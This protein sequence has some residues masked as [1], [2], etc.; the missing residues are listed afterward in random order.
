MSLDEHAAE[1]VSQRTRFGP[2]VE[3][4]PIDTERYMRQERAAAETSMLL[5]FGLLIAATIGALWLWRSVSRESELLAL[6]GV[7]PAKLRRYGA[8]FLS[9]IA[10]L[11]P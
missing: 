3:A 6:S 5:L 7:G 2:D 11:H 1:S 9:E 8:A 10:E 4:Y